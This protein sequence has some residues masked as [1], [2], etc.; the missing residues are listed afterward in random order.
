MIP[1][2]SRLIFALVLAGS[3]REAFGF[4]VVLTNDVE[5]AK[6]TIADYPGQQDVFVVA[7]QGVPGVTPASGAMIYHA[8]RSTSEVRYFAIGG[9]GRFALVERG[10]G[11]RSRGSSWRAF[12]V[13]SDDPKRPLLVTGDASQAVDVPALLAQYEAFENIAA[14]GERNAV[15]DAAVAAKAAQT[16]RACSSKIAAKLPW[17]AFATPARARLAK[18]AVSILE[19]LEAA[20]ADKDYAASIRAVRE[21]RV[22]Y[23]ADGGA[24]RLARTG[25]ALAVRFSDTS[26]NPRETA[27]LWLTDHL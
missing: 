23:Q 16:N 27:R 15:I 9:G 4:A 10:G 25:A 20:C 8:D 26:F 24:L 1:L 5:H 7:W 21:L 18:Q 14:P 22:D 3:G 6:I 17:K 19:A 2:V 11:R 12:D 13:I